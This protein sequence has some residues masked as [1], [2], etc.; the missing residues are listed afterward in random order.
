MGRRRRGGGGP[1][2]TEGGDPDHGW[3]SHPQKEKKGRQQK[4]GKLASGVQVPTSRG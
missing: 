2:N 1:D 4:V 3:V